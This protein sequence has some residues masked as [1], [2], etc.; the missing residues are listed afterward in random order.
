MQRVKQLELPRQARFLHN[1]LRGDQALLELQNIFVKGLTLQLSR[2]R[3][4][5]LGLRCQGERR[6]SGVDHYALKVPGGCSASLGG[7]GVQT[8]LIVDSSNRVDG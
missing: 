6:S 1:V 2:E 3:V 7:A 5:I 4:T 8:G